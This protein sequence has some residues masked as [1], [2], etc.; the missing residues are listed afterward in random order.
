MK[1][2][3]YTASDKRSRLFILTI[4]FASLVLVP[5]LIV[6]AMGASDIDP[7]GQIGRAHV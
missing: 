3:Y 1:K 5:A 2:I 6:A 7:A 4:F